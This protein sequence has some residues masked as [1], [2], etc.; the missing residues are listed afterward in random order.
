MSNIQLTQ[1]MGRAGRPQFDEY[2]VAVIMTDNNSVQKCRDSATGKEN[3]ESNLMDVIEENLCSAIYHGFVVLF[4]LI[5]FI[6]YLQKDLDTGVKWF[7]S[8]FLYVRMQKSNPN[9][10]VL[11]ELLSP[12][13]SI[14]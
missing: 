10:Q 14:I 4:K 13:N 7:Q 1:L 11:N 2:G 8:T 3:V 6:N 9:I 12:D 5:I